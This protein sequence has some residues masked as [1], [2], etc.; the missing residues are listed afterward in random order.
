MCSN[1]QGHYGLFTAPVRLL[2]FNR[3]AHSPWLTVPLA[4]DEILIV[5]EREAEVFMPFEEFVREMHDPQ[6]AVFS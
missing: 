6:P 2:E 3:P 5:A 4:E 1:Q